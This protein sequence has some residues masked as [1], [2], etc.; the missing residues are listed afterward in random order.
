MI[1]KIISTQSN[2][3]LK[4]NT[5]ITLQKQQQIIGENGNTITNFNDIKQVWC[6][7]S[8][9]DAGQNFSRMKNDIECLYHI[10][11]RY[12]DDAL[13]T[14]RITYKNRIFSVISYTSDGEKKD[15]ITFK[16]KELV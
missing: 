3:P 8:I 12:F 11:I 9:I 14:K 7:M 5:R 4:F 2:N 16:V 15:I 10:S 6:S 1:N 13:L